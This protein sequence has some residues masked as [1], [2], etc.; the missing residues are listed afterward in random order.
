MNYIM[1]PNLSSVMA[2]FQGTLTSVAAARTPWGG[3][4]SMPQ[5]AS[6]TA[7]TL[8]CHEDGA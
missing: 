4:V 6:L 1:G 8:R 5:A 7:L 2:I 3:C